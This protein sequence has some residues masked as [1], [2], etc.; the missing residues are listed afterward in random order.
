MIGNQLCHFFKVCH[1]GSPC[2]DSTLYS[3]AASLAP[4]DKSMTFYQKNDYQKRE[5]AK[6]DESEAKKQ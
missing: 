5:L 1:D 4:S 6:K 2:T 3:C